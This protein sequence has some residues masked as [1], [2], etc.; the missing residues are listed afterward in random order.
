MGKVIYEKDGVRVI[1]T[2][3]TEGK[4]YTDVE[5]A[6]GQD[7]LGVTRWEAFEDR[8]ATVLANA[9]AGEARNCARLVQS[10]HAA[11]ERSIDLSN[12]LTKL[13]AAL[14]CML[15]GCMDMNRPE[16][17]GYDSCPAHLVLALEELLCADGNGGL[18]DLTEVVP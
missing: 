7:V 9:L 10:H 12:Q 2:E 1:E 8:P 13:R 17:E 16:D 4:F 11:V 18:V 5:R 6:A 3:R 15:L 14:K